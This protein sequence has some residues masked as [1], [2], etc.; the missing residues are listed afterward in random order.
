MNAQPNSYKADGS[1]RTTP[2]PPDSAAGGLTLPTQSNGSATAG[3][4]KG[5]PDWL[6]VLL[7]ALGAWN[8]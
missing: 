6:L 8:V 1:A 7:R 5:D 2:L 3:D 4:E